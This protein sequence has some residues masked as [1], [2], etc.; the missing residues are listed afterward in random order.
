LEELPSLFW[1]IPSSLPKSSASA[2][3]TAVVPIKSTRRFPPLRHFSFF[4]LVL[5]PMPRLLNSVLFAQLSPAHPDVLG[6]SSPVLSL[7]ITRSSSV[8]HAGLSAS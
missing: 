6:A 7:S 2:G 4:F 3:A 5:L 8:R 1:K